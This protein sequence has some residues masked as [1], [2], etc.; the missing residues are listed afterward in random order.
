MIDYYLDERRFPEAESDV[1]G[2]DVIE[3]DEG[4]GKDVEDQPPGHHGAVHHEPRDAHQEQEQVAPGEQSVAGTQKPEM[5]VIS[6]AF[7]P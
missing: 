1:V 7:N 6:T 3:S 4:H 5:M 2:G